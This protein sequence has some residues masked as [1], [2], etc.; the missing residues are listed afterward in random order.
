[1]LV[2][3]RA[4]TAA[5]V[6]AA[7]EAA[8]VAK[9]AVAQLESK[10]SSTADFKSLSSGGGGSGSADESSHSAT[11]S[12]MNK[13]KPFQLFFSVFSLSPYL[14]SVSSLLFIFQIRL[15]CL[16]LGTDR[17]LLNLGCVVIGLVSRGEK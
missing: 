17:R 7:T 6:A 10:S 2:D 15:L 9:A 3:G 16:V 13:K 11:A 1:M 8:A 12:W 14:T 5:A 4:G